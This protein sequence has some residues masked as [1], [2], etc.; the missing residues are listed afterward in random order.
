MVVQLDIQFL[1]ISVLHATQFSHV[2]HMDFVTLSHFKNVCMYCFH[3]CMYIPLIHTQSNVSPCAFGWYHMFVWPSSP[4]DAN[5]TTPNNDLD[6]DNL[7]LVTRSDR[8]LLVVHRGDSDQPCV[9]CGEAANHF[10][11]IGDHSMRLLGVCALCTVVAVCMGDDHEVFRWCGRHRGS[12]PE[13]MPRRGVRLSATHWQTV[14]TQVPSMAIPES[15]DGAR[16]GFQIVRL[17]SSIGLRPVC[18]RCRRRPTVAIFGWAYV[19]GAQYLPTEEHDEVLARGRVCFLCLR[20]ATKY[21][22]QLGI[23]VWDATTP[24][25]TLNDLLPPTPMTQS[26]TKPPIVMAKN[27]WPV[28]R[29]VLCWWKKSEFGRCDRP[30]GECDTCTNDGCPVY[31]VFSYTGNTDVTPAFTFNDGD[32]VTL[33]CICLELRLGPVAMAQQQDVMDRAMLRILP[34]PVCGFQRRM[35]EMNQYENRQRCAQFGCNT[36]FVMTR[37]TTHRSLCGVCGGSGLVPSGH[38]C[39]ICQ[40]T[41]QH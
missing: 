40:A 24:I 34:A 20:I 11:D 8:P 41:G 33:C 39:P 1:E 25:R 30:S 35:R 14:P 28:E 22:L 9:R 12:L 21:P 15:G 27:G 29:G 6:H 16:G 7:S 10:Y 37:H 26:V 38:L 19:G 3:I 2:C 4:T 17:P 5:M 18:E 23:P 36:G 32:T 31:G 13:H